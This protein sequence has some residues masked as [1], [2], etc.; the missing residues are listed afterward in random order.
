[1]ETDV[2]LMAFF[3]RAY[4]HDLG[5]LVMPFFVVPSAVSTGLLHRT[6]DNA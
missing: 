5:T 4:Q 1:M 2:G 6:S 3:S